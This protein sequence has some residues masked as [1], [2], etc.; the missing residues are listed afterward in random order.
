MQ[1]MSVSKVKRGTP[2][3]A[4]RQSQGGRGRFPIY[5]ATGFLGSGK[6][7]ALNFLAKQSEFVRTL[8][9]INEFGEI[10]LDHDLVTFSGDELAVQMASVCAVPSGET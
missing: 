8:V 7:T 3:N 1:K 5:A 6:T 4:R 10:G 9:L 2:L